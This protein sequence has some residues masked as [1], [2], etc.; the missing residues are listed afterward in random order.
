MRFLPR[1]ARA[2]QSCGFW[3]A[4]HGHAHCASNVRYIVPFHTWVIL[5]A[6]ASSFACETLYPA[7]ITY[8]LRNA[9]VPL[10]LLQA[11]P[12]VDLAKL[13]CT[14]PYIAVVCIFLRHK[15]VLEAAY[16]APSLTAVGRDIN[17]T[18]N[19]TPTNSSDCQLA[20]E[21]LPCSTSQDKEARS[22][23]S[24]VIWTAWQ[25]CSINTWAV[26]M[27]ESTGSATWWANSAAQLLVELS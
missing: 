1:G 22:R 5:T 13:H 14:V 21:S 16:I 24:Y 10:V 2:P 3:R 6:D 27:S 7:L 19:S 8:V 17:T 12:A 23:E 15:A 20:V 9:S 11:G 25:G 4:M 18:A 26:A